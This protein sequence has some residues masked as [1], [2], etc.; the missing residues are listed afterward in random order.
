M[1]SKRPKV[2]AGPQVFELWDERSRNLM[3]DFESEQEAL[4]VLSQALQ[5]HGFDYADSIVLIR[6]GPRGGLKRVAS[7]TELARRAR[8]ATDPERVRQGLKS[9]GGAVGP[10]T[11]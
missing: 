3:G 8:K 5:K 11:R 7:G 1:P 10:S 4:L 2:Q 6:V 9:S